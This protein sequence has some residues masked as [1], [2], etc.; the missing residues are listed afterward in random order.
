MGGQAHFT[1]I[2]SV[3]QQWD[4]AYLKD[5]AGTAPDAVHVVICDQ[6]GFHLKD[7][8]PRL[9]ERVRI[10]ALPAYSPELNPCGQ[11]W[12]IVR[13]SI[14][15]RVFT[16]VRRLR[17]AMVPAL[18]RWRDDAGSVLSLIGRPWLALKTQEFA[19]NANITL[20]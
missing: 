4:R 5:P 12:D 2:P 11:A 19:A 18:K 14:G 20:V 10:L 15:N 8:D 7:G 1:P 17:K 16:T 9:P 6:A 3:N 13:D